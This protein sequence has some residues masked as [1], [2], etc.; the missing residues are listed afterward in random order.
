MIGLET[1]F[2]CKGLKLRNRIVMPP[3]C[4]Y[5]AHHEDGMPTEWHYIHY[6][7]RAIGG[8]GLI[9]IEMTNVEPAGRISNRCLGLW[10]DDHI[11]AFR[12][13][14]RECQQHG[15][16][17]AIQIA[18]AGRKAEDEAVPVGPMAEPFNERYNTPRALT[19][20]EVDGLVTKFADAA[21][22]AVEAGVDAVELHG[23]HGYLIHQ[24]L[25]PY[26]NRRDDEYGRDRG[27][28]AERIV[29]AV[30]A[31]LPPEMPLM[32]RLSAV[33]YADG[34]YDIDYAIEIGRRLKA[35]GVDMFDIS[36]GG[37]GTPGKRKP[38]NS[39]GYQV[40]F[41]RAFKDALGLPVIAAGRLED[42]QVALK[43]LRDGDA[44]LVGVARG[45]LRNP[46]WSLQAIRETAG[47]YRE[48]APEP[49]WRAY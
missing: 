15:A 5:S 44:D 26:S 14:I 48:V 16:K 41:A 23:A 49:Y 27:L 34:G 18:H 1:P 17:V 35:A 36:S 25:S 9:I 8:T 2:E 11:P 47:L 24:F 29:R 12:R 6:V 22:R 43:A 40:P 46:Y 42:P 3:M 7:S 4:Q 39:P 30:K 31:V 45:M 37:E 33:E 19:T 32:I 21:R 13:I 28:F 38:G 20:E 10:S